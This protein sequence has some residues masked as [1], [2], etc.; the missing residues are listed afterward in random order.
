MSAALGFALPAPCPVC[1][2]PVMYSGRGRRPTYCSPKH[3]AA[4]DAASRPDR[5]SGSVAEAQRREGAEYERNFQAM[6]GGSIGPPTFSDAGDLEAIP[7]TWNR[8]TLGRERD[9]ASQWLAAQHPEE[10][11]TFG[12]HEEMGTTRGGPRMP[13]IGSSD[14][15]SPVAREPAA[16]EPDLI[17]YIHPAPRW[18]PPAQRDRRRHRDM[19][20]RITRDLIERQDRAEAAYRCAVADRERVAAVAHLPRPDRG[21][22]HLS[23]RRRRA[24]VAARGA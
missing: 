23:N 21:P 8:N 4:A 12:I 7:W 9:A 20:D 2:G 10:L 19:V 16:P 3:K 1:N 6:A 5:R 14:R 15:G 17:P 18:V 11:A 22:L 24:L 13:V